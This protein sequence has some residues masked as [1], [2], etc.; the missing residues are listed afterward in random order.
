MIVYDN[1]G[2]VTMRTKLDGVE[3][4]A[5][6]VQDAGQAFS[7]SIPTTGIADG[8]R[9]Y[10]VVVEDAAGNVGTNSCRT[11]CSRPAA[12]HVD[13]TSPEDNATVSGV[14]NLDKTL[15]AGAELGQDRVERPTGV[16][17]GGKIDRNAAMSW[18]TGSLPEGAYTLKA[19]I[20]AYQT[21]MATDTIAGDRSRTH[22]TRP[23]RP[24]HADR[25]AHGHAERRPRRRLRLRRDLRH[26][27]SSTTRATAAPARSPAPRARPP[28]RTSAR[29]SRSTA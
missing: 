2:T 27:A 9:T 17:I 15:G 22:A 7:R 19:T 5:P 24:R 11:S 20:A 4:G 6:I 14:V 21:V 18:S 1:P 25:H 23:R 26:D 16:S 10:T 8:M 13:I 29:R 3:F 28:A 12:P